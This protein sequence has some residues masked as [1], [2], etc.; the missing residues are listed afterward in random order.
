M[1]I[2]QF[3]S[4]KIK[5]KVNLVHKVE[6]RYTIKMYLNFRP[7]SFSRKNERADR[8]S[9]AQLCLVFSIRRSLPIWPRHPSRGS[10]LAKKTTNY[11]EKCQTPL[12][13]SHL[14]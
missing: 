12:A 10:G 14:F 6:L 4:S 8:R 2:L 5:V 13:H 3:I 7:Q 11:G 9:E 1:Y